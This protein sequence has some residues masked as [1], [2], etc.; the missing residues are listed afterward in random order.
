MR[1]LEKKTFDPAAFEKE[2]DA[3]IA[4]LT[5]QRR[6]QL[7]QAYMQEARKRVPRVRHPEALQRVVS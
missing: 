1:V 3:L 6:D 5:E 2:K 4:S 7:F